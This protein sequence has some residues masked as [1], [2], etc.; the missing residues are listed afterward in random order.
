MNAVRIYGT[1][2]DQVLY[3]LGNDKANILLRNGKSQL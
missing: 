2:G 1:A 3:P